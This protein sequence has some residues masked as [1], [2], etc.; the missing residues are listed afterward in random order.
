[1]KHC[2][3]LVWML[4]PAMV[5]CGFNSG[6]N[7]SEQV[8]AG[9]SASIDDDDSVQKTKKKKVRD[10]EDIDDTDDGNP[11]GTGSGS[12]S[13]TGTGGGTGTGSGDAQNPELF[14]FFNK[15]VRDAVFQ[16]A[17]I[18]CHV[19]P[20]VAADPRGPEKI[21][22]YGSMR[23]MLL[24]SESPV[25]NSLIAKMVNV[26]KH[27]GGDVC[28][29]GLSDPACKAVLDWF[30]KERGPITDRATLVK[31]VPANNGI[32]GI[33][34]RGVI[35]GWA[36]NPANLADSVQVRMY[37]DGDNKSGKTPVT[38]LANQE[39]YDS[40]AEGGHAFSGSMPDAVIDGKQHQA[41]F[42]Y[43]AGGVE[44]AVN[45]TPMTFYAY[46][47]NLTRGKPFFDSSIAG[48]ISG[49][50]CHTDSSYE[51][52]FVSLLTPS[53]DKGGSR[54]N[55]VF[56]KKGNGTLSHTGGAFCGNAQLCDNIRTWWDREFGP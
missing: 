17:C 13:G 53:P 48:S 33:T 30:E 46:K 23:P 28:P 29:N 22:V 55:N 36:T 39:G 14:A 2:L 45:G 7:K 50:G 16:K 3:L 47:P 54:D 4:V 37:I 19:G 6:A 1:M 44:T 49:C 25:K 56:I 26:I 52:R 12:V 10:S 24:D 38:F 51:R 21:Y 32:T 41:Y 5:G 35:N 11:T 42:Y 31:P 15:E 18:R 40:G 9:D 20:R 43:V 8:R 34:E 27:T